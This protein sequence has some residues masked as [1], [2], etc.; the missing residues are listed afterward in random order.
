MMDPVEQRFGNEKS[1]QALAPRAAR[2]R[3]T[4]LKTAPGARRML[5]ITAAAGTACSMFGGAAQATTTTYTLSSGATDWSVG[6]NW[7]PT[8]PAAGAG[9]FALYNTASTAA[10]TAVNVG[11]GTTITI[12]QI[13]DTN[14]GNWALTLGTA[15]SGFVLDSTG[16]NGNN[17][18]GNQTESAI[19]TS[20][21]GTL[22]IGSSGSPI[23]VSIANTDLAI[24]T[25]NAT[26]NVS[27]FGA[28]T[29]STAQTLRF[30]A[31]GSATITDNSNIGA[32]GSNIA[33]QN[34]GTS[35]GLTTLSGILGTSVSSVTQNSSGSGLTLT[36]ANSY[37][38][39]TTVNAGALTV[40]GAGSI[41]SSSGY[42]ISNGTLNLSPNAANTSS[43]L[44]SGSNLSLTGGNLTLTGTN[45]SGT[46]A[47]SFNAFTVGAGYSVVTIGSATGGI[48]EFS[49]AASSSAFARTGNG[50]A[51]IRG[52]ALNQSASTNVTRFLLGDG[53]A[54]LG[55]VGTNTLSNAGS[56][57]TTQALKIA[58]YL[59]G[60]VTTTG[61]G[62]NFVTY[63]STLGLRVLTSSE[64]TTLATG[65]T[66]AANP[67]NA[68][69]FNGTVTA[70]G[71]T[72]NS[73]LFTG[74]TQTLNGSGTLTVNS[75]AVAAVANSETIGSG[76]SSLALGNGE[77]VITPVSGETLTIATP[78]SVTSSGGLTKAGAGTLVLGA[79]DLYAGATTINQ[80]T[81]QIGNGLAGNLAS[82]SGTIT[83]NSG[84]SGGT[85]SVDLSADDA[86]ANT[87]VN[88]GTVSK[89]A[90]AVVNTLSGAIS[91][92][93]GVTMNL[94]GGTL[95]LG[96]ANSFT[97]A[98]AI[99]AG[100]LR[101]TNANAVQDSA[102]TINNGGTLDLRSNTSATFNTGG[103]TLAQGNNTTYNI[104]VDKNGSGTGQTLTL[105]GNLAFGGV[106]SQAANQT[107][108][109]TGSSNDTLALGTVT[110]ANP[111]GDNT[112]SSINAA[113]GNVSVTTFNGTPG[114]DNAFYLNGNGNF[115][116]G[117][118]QGGGG[119]GGVTQDRAVSPTVNTSGTVTINGSVQSLLV[120]K[121][122]GTTHTSNVAVNNGTLLLD[123]SNLATPTN[124]LNE[125][126]S[127]LNF[128]F[129]GGTLSINGK[130]SG[131]TS[132]D[133]FS[134]TTFNSGASAISLTNNGTS[135]VLK[136]EGITRN[137][138][139]TVDIT[140]PSG[141]LSSTNGVTTTTTTNV[142]GI[143]GG[144]AT[145]GGSTWAVAPASS[146]GAIAGLSTGSY[147]N[148]F[149]TALSAAATTA[150]I[151]VAAAGSNASATSEVVN[152]LR[153]N[154]ATNP[155][156]VDATNGLTLT[157][158]GIL[159]TSNVG[160]NLSS[161]SNGTLEGANTSDLVVI[162]NNTSNGLTIGST[163]ANDTGATALTKSGAGLLTLSNPTNTFT[164]VTYL[165]AG[166]VNIAADASLG[167]APGSVSAA[168]LTM[169]GG[170][171]QFGYAGSLATNRGITLG[172]KGGTIDTNG[173]ADSYAGVIAG[174]GALTKVG[175][176]TMTLSGTNS[177]TG[178]TTVGGGTFALSA[179]S[180]NNISSSPVITV[181]SGATLS[182]GSLSGGGITLS[183]SQVLGGIG[184]VTGVT[185]VASGSK[186]SAG[187]STALGT[188][189]SN[190][191]GTLTTGNEAWNGGAT[192]TWKLTSPGNNG[193]T[194]GSG[195]SGTP[196]LSTTWDDL[197]MG[198]L[199]LGS[200]GGS[201]SPITLQLYTPT[202]INNNA[203]GEYSWIIAQTN[204]ST[205]PTLPG[206]GYAIGASNNLLTE[207]VSTGASR[208]FVLDTSNFS[209]NG[210][211]S[212]TSSGFS[213]ELAPDGTGGDYDLVLDYNAAPEPGTAILVLAGGLPM[214]SARRRRRKAVG[215]AG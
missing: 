52:T 91:G 99:T 50:T 125:S 123:F 140:Q 58:P 194:A 163:I 172:V 53:G 186:I 166:T 116:F 107:L 207:A 20:N 12:G 54:S 129:G 61:N 73:L 122:T 106:T 202:V 3:K 136:L 26:G 28:I 155:A 210:A 2:G 187:S 34:V 72:V 15:T 94:A 63:D 150:N 19:G 191:T 83:I 43:M 29:A 162:Q 178:D 185:T 67:V 148:T 113:G 23:P 109:V 95:V 79:T 201:N 158:G 149:T 69:A 32:S 139:G 156:T 154:D 18:F 46:V 8:G 213:L 9:N 51:L 45:T 16:I 204:S 119:G 197:S 64:E 173:N 10:S 174:S 127:N 84:T 108:N 88:N 102:V 128:A 126:N 48:T 183:S 21:T 11:S 206:S 85:L 215:N 77:G 161:I 189:S 30:R 114:G 145:V 200:A 92:S 157:T 97:G 176:S 134:G 138:G 160:N 71:L 137:V 153:F 164:G 112:T 209:M 146:G 93:G 182:T 167:T 100:T 6:A 171:L 40:S 203:G 56:S 57:D 68:V 133:L 165:N 44:D 70:A 35:S 131:A 181:A 144:Y 89:T 115:T 117:S 75:G 66:T 151:D 49:A 105:G 81:L 17:I 41:A 25:T 190:T 208:L 110:I 76:F 179:S 196:G 195:G 192:Y 13:A 118:I 141:T 33:I 78:I 80:G 169:N 214:L 27:I 31:N 205:A 74:A 22:T 120:F 47:E 130:A 36:A 101:L 1:N 135:V 184:T 147:T 86:L 55:M 198:T 65:S 193:Q 152:S 38:G 212:P 170:T 188:G 111:N 4:N 142:G 7:T 96:N 82:G 98:T 199:N 124:L 39:A 87:I 121:N 60:D 103:V 37:T 42:T 168:Q 211:V 143:L 159:V 62:T 14:T 180:T 177:Y 59:I 24:G 104:N 175:A 5:A 90:G 132:Q